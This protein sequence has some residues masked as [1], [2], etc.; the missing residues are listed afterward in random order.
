M[1]GKESTVRKE[2]TVRTTSEKN[3]SRLWRALVQMVKYRLMRYSKKV[4]L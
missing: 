1:E 4:I 2:P 3:S